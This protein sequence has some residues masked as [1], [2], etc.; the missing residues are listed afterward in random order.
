MVET[1]DG[2]WYASL[3][4]RRN[5][6]GHSPLGRETFLVGVTWEDGWPVF[7][8]GEPLLLSE[9]VEA[10]T[11]KTPTSSS[12]SR[13][14]PVPAPWTDEFGGSDLDPSWYQLR[15]PYTENFKVFNGRIVLRPNV[16]GLGDRDVPA[17]ILRKQTSLNM[18]FSAEL[19]GFKGQLGPRNRIGVSAYL[20]EFQHQDIGLRGCANATGMCLYTELRRNGTVDVSSTPFYPPFPKRGMT[21]TA[22]NKKYWQTQLNN[23]GQ[24]LSSG[25]KLHV[26]ATP[27]TYAL[28]YSFDNGEPQYVA[29]IESRWQ[30]FAPGGWF[31][32]SGNS[33]ALFAT[34]DGEPWPYDAPDV[35]FSKV[36][37]TYYAEDIPDYDRW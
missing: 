23:S 10:A 24:G 1:A 5:I 9:P 21:D 25:L 29:E 36:T 31:V 2:A 6:N 16:F 3:L 13:R 20:S 30:A 7:N 15:T 19:L 17:A 26:R 32:F 22:T 33:F 14:R 12:S 27:L 11:N 28:G 35:G 4:A 34:G 8:N 37:E 18:T